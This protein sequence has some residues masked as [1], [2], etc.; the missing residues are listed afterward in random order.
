MEA[1]KIRNFSIIAHIDHGKSTL[2]DRLLEKTGVM[3]QRKK[4]DQAL[5]SLEIERERGI[6]VKSA[7]VT[8]PYRD[9][10]GNDYLLNL[11]DTPGHVDFSYEV[12]RSLAACEGAILVVDATQGIEAQTISNFYK[13]F[14]E[15]LV[16]LPVINKVDL[17]AAQVDK[18]SDE[19]EQEF[20]LDKKD[21]VP[22]SAKTGL[23]I[24][25]LLDKIIEFFPPP[26]LSNDPSKL[27]TPNPAPTPA[28][29]PAV[30]KL[31]ALI[32]DSFFDIFRGVIILVRVF[33]GTL[34]VGDEVK[35]FH[36]DKVYEVEEVGIYRLEREK[37]HQLSFG[38]VGYVI[39]GIK[40][41]NTVNIGDTLTHKAE[42]C[43]L[44][45]KGYQE[46]KPMVYAGVYPLSTEDFNDLQKN[47]NKLKLN[48]ASLSF[49]KESSNALGFGFRCGFLGVLH[50]EIFQERLLQE[51]NTAIIL[52][53][54]SVKYK[55]YYNKKP[56]V[57]H[58]IDNPDKFP[59]PTTISRMEEPFI[60]ANII[61][62]EQ[63]FGNVMKLIQE[64]RGQ[65]K[66]LNY[67]S[68]GRLEAIFELPLAEVVFDFYDK[69]KSITKGY[70]SFDYEVIDYR[71]ADIVKVSVL[72]N[73]EAVDALS[74]IVHRDKARARAKTVLEKLKEEIPR[75]MFSIPLQ[76]AIGNTIIARET[77][78]AFR[79]DVTAKCYGGDISRKR[80]LLEKQRQGK[81][82]MKSFGNVDIPQK[83]FINVL[84]NN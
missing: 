66:N 46:I 29:T 40:E 31:Q 80:K 39:L 32:F 54:P 55:I 37:K 30:H 48:D 27:N 35:F 65:Q 53:V 70:A 10:Q 16:V 17:P 23:G 64:N 44:A 49:E 52:T 5:D 58:Y 28:H 19:I 83:A 63:Y 15:N 26:K 9:Q 67:L 33:S 84:K 68:G 43:D 42:P 34:K 20:S 47:L 60:K 77:I 13:A 14:E 41:I 21:I 8:L 24:D 3:D 50:M 7:L 38:E 62:P 79:K 18:V 45:L 22:I 1:Q 61:V 72:I 6:T 76:A 75:H 81:K 11:I 2:S 4:K 78:S 69:L 36:D 56:D 74:F 25:A 59:E 82:K 71:E 57:A 73:K 51:F 12:S